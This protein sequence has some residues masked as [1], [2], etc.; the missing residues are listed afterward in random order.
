MPSEKNIATLPC[1]DECLR[2]KHTALNDNLF[3][4]ISYLRMNFSSLIS[5]FKKILCNQWLIWS[6][7]PDLNRH[8]RNER[9]ILSLWPPF[10]ITSQ[11]VQT[12]E[13]PQY[14]LYLDVLRCVGMRWL[15]HLFFTQLYPPG[16]LSH[17]SDSSSYLPDTL[18]EFQFA[19]LRL[20]TGR[21]KFQGLVLT[22]D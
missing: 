10:P 14:L 21:R 3:E 22:I 20:K 19:K 9:G 15:C 16:G 8:A 5:I 2:C 18:E 13:T 11:R 7:G 12:Q 6:Q 17:W 1:R 4:P